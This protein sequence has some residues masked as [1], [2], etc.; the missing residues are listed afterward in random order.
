MAFQ[1]AEITAGRESHETKELGI[2][3]RRDIFSSL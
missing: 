3:M 1:L 2:N